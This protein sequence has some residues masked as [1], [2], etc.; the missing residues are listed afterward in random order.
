MLFLVISS[1]LIIP[2]IYTEKVIDPTLTPRLLGLSIIISVLYLINIIG[3]GKNVGKFSFTSNHFFVAYL[4]FLLWSITTMFFAINPTEG[5]F[6]ITK[7]FLTIVLIIYASKVFIEDTRSITFLIKVVLIS[8]IIATTVGF[9]QYIMNVPGKS[10]FKLFMALYDIKGLMAQKNQFSISLFL[11][12]PFT[13]YGI[14][15]MKKYWRALSIYSTI[16][17]LTLIIIVQTRSVWVAATLFFLVFFAQQVVIQIKRRSVPK[18]RLLKISAITIVST[19]VLFSLSFIVLKKTDALETVQYRVLSMFDMESHDNQGRLNAWNATFEMSKDNLI[20]GV[21]AGNWKINIPGYF[22]YN[23][24]SKYQNWRR[25]HN[26]F[27]WML[28]EKGIIGFILY[29][30]IFLIAFIYSIIVI[31]K[32]KDLNRITLITLINSGI[33]GYLII[34]QLTFPYERINHQVYLSIMFAII[35]SCYYSVTKDT[36]NYKGKAFAKIHPYILVILACSIYYS[37]MLVQSELHLNKL[38]RHK[39]AGDWKEVKIEADKAF[40]PIITLDPYSSPIHL[41]IGEA[42]I[43]MNK[44]RQAFK[45]L[46]TGLNY[47]P[48]NISILNNLAIVSADMNDSSRAIYYLNES[49]KVYPK[50]EASLFNKANVYLRFK[51]YEKSYIALLHCNTEN[52]NPEYD[53]FMELLNMRI[54]NR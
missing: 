50:Y 35:I 5:L 48:A 6:D 23:V 41:H 7:V 18:P 28:S 43:Y 14:F 30:L 31:I 53:K 24:D 1:I 22:P 54:N 26:D 20:L 42:N 38:F 10:G 32:E 13:V 34:S 15:S 51:D 49:L 4:V 9:Y 3:K 29:T 33:F 52:P 39:K 36:K 45:D 40:S 27:L 11:M 25:P 21:G 2:F 37:A 16:A 47:F 17:I 46:T 12:L 44:K 19:I 8:A